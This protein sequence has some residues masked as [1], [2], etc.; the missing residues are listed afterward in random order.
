MK[1]IYVRS[2]NIVECE[3]TTRLYRTC[4]LE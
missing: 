2:Y 1:N 3:R 4:T